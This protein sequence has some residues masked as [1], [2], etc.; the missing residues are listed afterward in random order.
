MG[1]RPR[2]P[3]PVSRTTPD[4]TLS[5][6]GGP[7]MPGGGP[8]SCALPCGLNETW[9]RVG[10][11]SDNRVVKR[12]ACALVILI[13]LVLLAQAAPALAWSNGV[14]GPNSYGTHD[15]ILDKAIHALGSQAD[16]I[17]VRRA[18]RATDDPDTVD[19]IDHAS[20]TWWHVYDIWGDT[21]GGAPRGRQ[22]LVQQG[23]AAT[24]PG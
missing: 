5:L 9:T 3:G 12:A 6:P 15:W 1:V 22:G 7:D 23:H 19:G 14:D 2:L 8:V 21:W 4:A 13:P 24:Q 20:G 11:R 18:L 16:W 17:C 10:P